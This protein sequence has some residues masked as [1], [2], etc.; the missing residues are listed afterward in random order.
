MFSGIIE[1]LGRVTTVLRKAQD[2]V[3]T[4]E[5]RFEDMETGESI[6]IN[7]VCLTVTGLNQ[8]GDATFFVSS[9]T[10]S[11]SNLGALRAGDVVNLERAVRLDTRL[12]GHLVQ[13]HVDGK[14]V[15]V[16]IM[17]DGNAYQL[18]FS[19]PAELARYCIEKG[20]IALNGV[21]LTINSVAGKGQQLPG[22][23]MQTNESPDQGCLI[24]STIIPHTWKTT[25]LNAVAIGEE[26]NVEVDVIAK[27]VERLCRP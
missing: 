4:I 10:V 1:N 23:K 9:E 17:L 15:L 11:R 16:S 12:S 20:S 14:A 13:G 19:L 26:V 2:L 21:S 18:T 25:N 3:L 24:Q 6:A 5:N 7:G 27:Y 8:Q 22:S